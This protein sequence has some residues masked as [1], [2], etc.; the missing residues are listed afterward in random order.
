MNRVH[1]PGTF[2][3]IMTGFRC[4]ADLAR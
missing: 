1:H 3:L 2:H 4:A